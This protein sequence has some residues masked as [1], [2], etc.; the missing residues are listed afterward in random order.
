MK[1]IAC[2]VVIATALAHSPAAR[3]DQT[4]IDHAMQQAVSDYKKGG[5]SAMHT[6]ASLCYDSVDYGHSN[7]AQTAAS[8]VEYCFAYDTAA[9]VILNERGEYKSYTGYFSPDGV[10]VRAALNLEKARVVTLPEQFPPYWGKRVDYIKQ[11][12]P[13]ML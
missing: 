5:E 4:N 1:L 11:T 3:A 13:G 12:I 10:M 7:R 6:R 8:G 2:L 9:V